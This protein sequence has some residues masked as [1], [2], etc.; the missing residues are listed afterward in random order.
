MNEIKRTATITWLK[1]NNY[2]TLLQCYAL[3]NTLKNLG[4][5]NKILDD[6]WII[7][8]YQKTIKYRI[9]TL[10]HFFLSLLLRP[11][12]ITKFNEI[13]P[14]TKKKCRQ[15]V[16][17]YLDVDYNVIDLKEVSNR[18]DCFICGSDQIWNPGP[19]WYKHL[20]TS[21]Y[22]AGFTKKKKIA[23]APSIGVSKYPDLHKQEFL[24]YI[25][26]FAA[27]SCREDIGCQIIKEIVEREVTKVVDPTLLLNEFQWRNLIGSKRAKSGYILCYFLSSNLWYWDYVK[28][29]SE[30]QKLK[31][32]CFDTVSSNHSIDTVE[33]HGG[34]KEFLEYIDRAN[35]VLTDSFHATLFSSI[36]RTDFYTFE[37]FD[38]SSVHYAQNIRLKNFFSM[39]NVSD[40]YITRNQKEECFQSIPLDFDIIKQ[41][42]ELKASSSFNYLKESVL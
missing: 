24:S 8:P 29:V 30:S 18:Y 7:E 17:R 13:H 20:N 21:F 12:G 2:G 1:Y 35:I 10:Y 41:N 39:I 9:A 37:R 36:L 28:K 14:V 23:Y 34:P 40:R 16:Q 38:K 33:I 15:F 31:I 27:L 19:S 42:I 5:Q 3:Q 4:L 22:Y 11:L 6:S 26:D 32:L 25:S